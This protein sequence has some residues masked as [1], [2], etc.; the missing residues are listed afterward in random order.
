[1]RSARSDL[2]RIGGHQHA[3]VRAGLARGALEGLGGGAEIARAVIDDGDG[4]GSMRAYSTPLVLGTAVAWRGSISTGGAQRAREALEAA[5]DDMVVVL[6]V[7]VPDV[8]REAAD[9]GEGLEPFLEQL[10]VHLAELGLG[11]IHLPDQVRPVGG[12]ERDLGQRLVHRDHGAAVAADAGAVAQRLGQA[13]AQHD[14]DILGRVVVVDMQVALGA[15]R[16][17]D[18]AVAR[19]LLQHVVEEADAGLD[20]VCAGAVEIDGDG[21]TG[22]LGLRATRTP[23]AR[24]CRG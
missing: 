22:L 10:G 20:V 12:V 2:V 19:Q 23:A 21:D 3:L 8:Q 17:V 9:L 11:E 18:Q 6:A 4:H 5:F 7:L 24:R 1:M 15:Q 13:F 16:D 14:A